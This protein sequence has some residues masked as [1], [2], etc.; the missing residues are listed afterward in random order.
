MSQLEQADKHRIINRFILGVAIW[1]VI[2]V[3]ITFVQND[4]SRGSIFLSRNRCFNCVF[5][6][7]LLVA[8]Q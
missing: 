6:N 7:I 3:I 8:P 4:Y 1:M 2:L 5:R